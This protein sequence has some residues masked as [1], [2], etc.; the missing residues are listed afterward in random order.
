M[1]GFDARREA[2][3]TFLSLTSLARPWILTDSRGVLSGRR[4]FGGRRS[5]FT[6]RAGLHTAGVPCAGIGAKW[7]GGQP[8]AAVSVH[9]WRDRD[10]CGGDRSRP[11]G[12]VPSSVPAFLS[13][14]ARVGH[15]GALGGGRKSRAVHSMTSWRVGRAGQGLFGI[16]IRMPTITGMDSGMILGGAARR[17]PREDC[18]RRAR[19]GVFLMFAARGLG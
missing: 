17:R 16:C 10:E 6:S 19:F 2:R 4:A 5:G 1:D 14:P 18:A 9:V 12:G 8:T 13:W 7:A 11:A 3:S 15:A